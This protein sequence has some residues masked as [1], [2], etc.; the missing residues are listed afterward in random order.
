[1][2]LTKWIRGAEL[3]RVIAVFFGITVVCVELVAAFD[4]YESSLWTVEKQPLAIA[5]T[6][7]LALLF[8]ITLVA[9]TARP[10]GKARILTV[11]SAILLF[12][13][14]FIANTLINYD[15]NRIPDS[16]YSFFDTI[17]VD[18]INRIWSVLEAGVRQI[19]TAICWLV[20][21]L[22][23]AGE[24]FGEPL[25]KSVTKRV[26][27]R[28]PNK[29]K[30]VRFQEVLHSNNGQWPPMPEGIS[31]TGQVRQL[32]K[33]NPEVLG[34]KPKE[35]AAHYGQEYYHIFAKARSEASRD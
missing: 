14:I 11:T 18:H 10:R 25:R 35:L 28:E 16:V 20:F 6:I 4:V 15:H 23:W 7:G 33:D 32:L 34:H 12:F 3:N 17:K 2:R 5:K 21:G 26:T 22:L 30:Q 29:T 19:V 31:R 1:M 24:A 13:F 27:R 8:V 9:Q